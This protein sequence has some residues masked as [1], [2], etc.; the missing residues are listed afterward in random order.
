MDARTGLRRAC[1]TIRSR[2]T[3]PVRGRQGRIRG[4]ASQAERF[5]KQ[6]RLQHLQAKLY[7]VER[8]IAQGRVSVC[9]GGRRMAKLRHGMSRDQAGL[10]QAGLTQVGWRARWEAARWFLTADGDASKP[11]GNQTIRVHP[12]EQWLEIRLPTPL[13]YLSNTP[14]RAAT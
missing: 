2:L 9:R 3:T 6:G 11:W 7:E 12:D 14:G 13:A 10:T 5:A 1:G 8:R 4:Y